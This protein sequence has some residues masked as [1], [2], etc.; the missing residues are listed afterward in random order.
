MTI[1]FSYDRIICQELDF[2]GVYPLGRKLLLWLKRAVLLFRG[3]FFLKLL[4]KVAFTWKKLI[5]SGFLSGRSA[6]Q[7]VVC[8]NCQN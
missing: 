6:H 4:E 8:F 1:S 5:I 2:C 3:F 7:Q